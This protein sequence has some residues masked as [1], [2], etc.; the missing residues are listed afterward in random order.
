MVSADPFMDPEVYPNPEKYDLYRFYNLRAQP[1]KENGYQYVTNSPQ[2]LL[3]GHGTHA[4]P[5]RFFASNEMKI[6]LCHLLLKYDWKLCDGE[7]TRPLNLQADQG[8][9]TNPVAKIQMRRRK[10]EIDLDTVTE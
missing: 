6:A 8:Y 9:L 10:E 4:C 1:V 7:T 2:H 3:F 5:G